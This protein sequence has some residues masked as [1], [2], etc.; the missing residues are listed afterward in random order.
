MGAN[1]VKLKPGND[2]RRR[3]GL[4]LLLLLLAGSLA[5]LAWRVIAP[6]IEARATPIAVAREELPRLLARLPAEPRSVDLHLRVAAC[7]SLLG[8]RLGAWQQLCV[9]ELLGGSPVVIRAAR[10]RT[11]EALG[12]LSDAVAT[13]RRQWR[14][15]PGDLR[16][17]LSLHRLLTLRGDFR[18]ACEVALAALAHH[19]DDPGVLAAAGEACFNLARY[20]E[21]IRHFQAARKAAPERLPVAVQLGVALLRAE[22]GAEAE[23]ILAEVARSPGAPPST[24]EFL[25]QARF[26]LGRTQDAAESFRRAEAAAPSAGSAFGLALAA[27]AGNDTESAGDA[28]QRA[29]E[30]DPEH[31]AAA[32]TLS[33]LLRS[34]GRRAEAAAVQ[35]RLALALG[36]TTLAAGRLREA[37]VRAE[38]EKR[39]PEYQAR[40]WRDLARAHEAAEDG[41]SAIAALR[42]AVA[43]APKDPSLVRQQVETAL[44][45][46]APEEALRACKAYVQLHPAAPPPIVHWWQFRAYRQLQDEGKAAG[47]LKTASAADPDHPQFVTWQA[48]LILEGVPDPQQLATAE[49]LLRRSLALRETDPDSLDALAEV[50]V[51]LKRW[52]DAASVLR[53]ALALDPRRNRGRLWLQLARCDRASGRTVEAGWAVGRYRELEGQHSRLA[54]RRSEAASRPGDGRS[55]LA[56]AQAALDADRAAEARAA[57]RAAV[58]AAPGAPDPFLALA[59]AC[60]RLGRLEDRIVAMEAATAR[61]PQQAR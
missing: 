55:L 8:D 27:L 43:C 41:P 10:A 26:S 7:Y 1:A 44:A 9:A 5:L 17:A 22:R 51:R 24:W 42:R 33:Q 25:G 2:P 16:T 36:D 6:R 40:L 57:A 50:L 31:E 56:W 19:P 39:P 13:T 34:R 45:V 53:R 20:P 54:R 18:P 47:A 59:V 11:A 46:F 3:A 30:R 14:A 52:E 4:A 48:R 49:R 28:L 23:P 37:L 15:A 60:Q 61:M 38:A 12:Q 32:T 35:G 58:R 29:L 21:A